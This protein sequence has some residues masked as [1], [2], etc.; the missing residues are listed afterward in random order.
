MDVSV[1][2][3]SSLPDIG[4]RRF[5]QKNG[6]FNKLEDLRQLGAFQSRREVQAKSNASV[7][8]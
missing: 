3:A 7:S 2:S 4:S 8:Q 1:R 5:R 6:P